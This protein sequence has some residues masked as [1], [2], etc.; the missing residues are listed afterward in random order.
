MS[1]MKVFTATETVC[2]TAVQCAAR[3]LL[4][5]FVVF[6]VLFPLP[7]AALAWA[8]DNHVAGVST[9]KVLTPVDKIT[10]E[11]AS[12]EEEARIRSTIGAIRYPFNPEVFTVSVYDETDQPDLAEAAAYYEYPASVVHIRR[13]SFERYPDAVLGRLV[14]HELG[15]MVDMLY[16]DDSDRARVGAIRD[17]PK[18][19]EWDSRSVDWAQ[20]PS[21]DFAETFAT[22]TQPLSLE[23]MATD[24][25]PVTEEATLRTVLASHASDGT[26]T[27]KSIRTERVLASVSD[28]IGAAA[29]QRETQ[30]LIEV[31]AVGALLS[32]LVHGMT[33]GL[34][35]V[36]IRARSRRDA[37]ARQGRAVRA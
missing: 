11:N 15:H 27:L 6:A 36:R 29:K 34:R 3:R 37:A 19:L 7:A 22:L 26:E 4:V 1:E 32:G 5:L 31:L 10:I 18:G 35:T 33:T 20:R 13:G 17:Y 28:Q 21:E 14:A 9:G 23:P 24:Y 16:L 12:P 30:V 8:R 25:G 2:T